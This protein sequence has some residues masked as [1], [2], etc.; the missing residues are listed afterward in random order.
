MRKLLYFSLSLLLGMALLFAACSP[1]AQ[2]EAQATPRPQETPPATVQVAPVQTGTI[3]SVLTYAG[4]LQ[5]KQAVNV[6][7]GATG[8]IESLQVHVGDK[9]NAG[10]TIAIIKHDNYDAQVKQAEAALATAQLNLTKMEQGTR[11]EQITADQAAVQVAR[12][13]LNDTA[14]VNDNQRTVAATNLANA[15]ASLQAAQTEYDKIAWAGDVGA[16]SQAIQL[17][18]ATITYQSALA[19]YNLATNPSDSQLAPLLNQV[20]QAELNLALAVTPYRETD[21][22][23]ARISI[24]QAEAAVELARIQLDEAT[25]KAPFEGVVAELFVDVGTTVNPQTTVATF[26]SKQV[27]A[28]I[29]IEQEQIVQVAENQNVTFQTV[30][31]PGQTFLGV[32]TSISPIADATSHT[33]AVKVTPV[34]EK[35]LLHSGMYGNIS[36]LTQKTNLAALVPRSAVSQI[37]NQPIVYVV[38]LG[39]LVEQRA[40]TTG[41]STDKQIEILAGLTPGERVV[42][43]GQENLADGAQV[44]VT[45][46][47]QE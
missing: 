42:V 11:P 20:S 45:S 24:Q 18:Q 34:D 13:A 8:R 28:V 5:A 25:I 14:H 9:L 4:V 3:T 32:V 38:K 40:V 47:L 35:G 31:Y 7:P 33:F 22:Q 41:I 15:Q 23:G 19:S 26:I 12:A 39:N 10:D 2:P 1:L 46:S 43:A 6:I 30:T 21:F 17:R 16:T 29:N 37:D 44:N 27:Q 36:I